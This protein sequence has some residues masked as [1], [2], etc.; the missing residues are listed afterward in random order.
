LVH[1]STEY[2]KPY[3]KLAE[4][5]LGLRRQ[6]GYSFISEHFMIRRSYM[7]D[8]IVEVHKRT[9][10]GQSWPRLLLDSIETNDLAAGFSE[11]ETYGNYLALHH[12]NSFECR[13]LKSL[14]SGAKYFGKNPDKHDLFALMLAGFDFV[15]FE[16]WQSVDRGRMTAARVFSKSIH[17]VASLS[18][19]V[20]GALAEKRLR[21]AAQLCNEPK[22]V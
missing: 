9:R 7:H 12:K 4:R 18:R 14:R 17:A 1:P 13:P 15:T 21:A 20:V 22:V 2:H 10:E 8:L 16:S 11:Y 5:V 3:F 6:V 19:P